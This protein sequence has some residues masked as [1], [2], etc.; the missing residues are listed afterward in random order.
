[1][2]G[3][4]LAAL[5]IVGCTDTWNDHYDAGLPEGANAGSL[6]STIKDNGNLNNFVSVLEATGYDASLSSSQVFTVF[7]PTDDQF[8]KE[9]AN[10]W[11]ALYNQEKQQGKKD[12]DNRAIK[13]FV[14]N[15]IALYNHSVAKTGADSIIMM[16]G[17]YLVLTPQTLGGSQLRLTVC[18]TPWTRRWTS[19]PMCLRL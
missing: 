1:V 19:F 7:A 10:Q 5:A 12:R 15:H 14:Q 16:N 17:K 8:T 2:A 18:C 3:L 6:W 9:Q 11:I 4:A 13:E